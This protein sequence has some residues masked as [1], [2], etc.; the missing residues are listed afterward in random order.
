M[1]GGQA[2]RR[3]EVRDLLPALRAALD[4][5]LHHGDSDGDGFIDYI[6][7]TGHGLANQGWK[8]SGDSI[9]WRSGELAEGP[10]ALCE[11]QGYA[12]EAALAGARL[13]DAFGEPG[14]RSLREW[15]ATLKRRFAE[16]YWVETPEGPISRG[17]PG[18]AQA[19]VDTLTSN[20]GHLLGTGILDPDEEAAIAAL[21]VGPTMLSGYGV[22]TMSTEA[23]GYWP[24]SYHGGSVWTHDSAII[25]RGMA[26]AGLARRGRPSSIEGLLA[27]AEGFG[28]PRAGAALRRRGERDLPADALPG[29]VPAAGVVGGGSSHRRPDRPR[30]G[31]ALSR[32]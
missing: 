1:R 27:A 14:A 11:V 23:G 13:L 4:W 30:G 21:L 7:E 18:R 3:H 24:L 31:G 25:A 9:Q 29:R 2:C 17:R 26:L 6:D 12:Y 8:D 20:I 28:V 16:S 15:A 5:L 10:I 19:P 22:R 32:P